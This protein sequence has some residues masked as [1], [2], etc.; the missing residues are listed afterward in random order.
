MFI[1]CIQITIN[2]KDLLTEFKNW[3]KSTLPNLKDVLFVGNPMYD[4]CAD[5][6]EARL[7]VLARLP[8]VT[9]IDGELVKPSEVDAAKEYVD[10]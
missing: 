9:K 7:R 5:R 6:N 2:N 10:E 3:K 4:G 1:L 8:Q